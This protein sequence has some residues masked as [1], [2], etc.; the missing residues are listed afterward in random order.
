MPSCRLKKYY[1]LG[2]AA[3]EDGAVNSQPDV[4]F[5]QALRKDPVERTI[6]VQR[7]RKSSYS[8]KT[9]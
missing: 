2:G 9:E 7:K 8:R 1:R 3:G 6:Q 5:V 4:D